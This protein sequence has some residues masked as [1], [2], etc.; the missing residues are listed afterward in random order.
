MGDQPCC[1][2]RTISP[3][4]HLCCAIKSE[5]KA[6]KK[7]SHAIGRF[8]CSLATQNSDHGLSSI[9]FIGEEITETLFP[10]VV[11]KLL[12]EKSL[13]E[14]FTALASAICYYISWRKRK[15]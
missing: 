1:V 3:A 11:N 5:R 8:N 4:G 2:G 13:W 14:V 10:R 7:S 12:E 9:S 15:R 6:E